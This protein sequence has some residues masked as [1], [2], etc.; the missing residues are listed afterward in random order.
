LRIVGFYAKDRSYFYL[1]IIGVRSQ[2]AYLPRGFR[3]H[4]N[5]NG[6]G[7]KTNAQHGKYA[8]LSL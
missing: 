3:L 1:A 6:G 2:Q 7:V 5:S 8:M 4:K